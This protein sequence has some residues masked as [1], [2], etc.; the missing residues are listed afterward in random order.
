MTGLLILRNLLIKKHAKIQ[1][2][3]EVSRHNVE[4]YLPMANKLIPV[5]LIILINKMID[6]SLI[7][8]I[9]TPTCYTKICFKS[10]KKTKKYEIEK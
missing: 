9:L 6:E 7:W 4:E 3:K 5:K 8:N 2:I 10:N 1:M